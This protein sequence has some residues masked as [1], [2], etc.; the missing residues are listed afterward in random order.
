[1]SFVKSDSVDFIFTDPPYGGTIQYLSLSEIWNK[2][3]DK[4]ANFKE[5]IIID[6]DRKKT[7][8]KYESDL[9]K[10]FSECSR[11][12]KKNKIMALT[13][14]A[15][16]IK[17]FNA[18]INSCLNAGFSLEYVSHQESAVSSATQGLNWKTTLKGDFILLFKN[19]KTPQRIHKNNSNQLSFE[20]T[21]I[22][23][24]ILQKEGNLDFATIF[25]L[26][27]PK[28]ISLGYL[29]NDLFSDIDVYSLLN[30]NFNKKIKDYKILWNIR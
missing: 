8:E 21:E 18:L 15:R 25:S 14:N 23:K 12:L 10:S 24:N 19:K 29:N 20:I 30:K 1:M 6:R 16:D 4:K 9:T 27:L 3:I 13:F 17:V 7:L 22:I 2:L 28:L 5:E 11:V 26:L